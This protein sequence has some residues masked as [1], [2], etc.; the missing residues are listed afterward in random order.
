MFFFALTLLPALAVAAP[1]VVSDPYP[2]ASTPKPTICTVYIDS[3]KGVDSA[4]A[5]DSAGNPFCHY[6]ISG[7]GAGSHAAKA[8][9]SIVDP[10][11]G[12][13][14]SGMSNTVNFAKPVAPT[15]PANILLSPK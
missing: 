12:S 13:L 5:V 2:A 8:T 7:V 11:W 6:D 15:A 3:D 9:F 14:T 1:F 10:I 4:V